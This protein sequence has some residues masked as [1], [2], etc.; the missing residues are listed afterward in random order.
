MTHRAFLLA[1]A[2]G[3]LKKI[4]M[5]FND[6]HGA[7]LSAIVSR[8]GTPIAWNIPKDV[9]VE[10]FSALA[11]TILGAS[12]VIY[13]G[14]SKPAPKR[15]LIESNEGVLVVSGLGTKAFVAAMFP[16]MNDKIDEGMEEIGQL[17]MNVL[18]SQ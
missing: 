10:N 14:M 15:I 17:I 16:A 7:L 9:T 3:E 18:K 4:L 2:V 11:A 6:K 5:D 1:S 13:A 8:V 12:E